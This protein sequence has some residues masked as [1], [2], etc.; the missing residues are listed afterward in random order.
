MSTWKE[1]AHRWKIE[2]CRNL[3]TDE[4]MIREPKQDIKEKLERWLKAAISLARAPL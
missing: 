2:E 3:F 4:P 1:L